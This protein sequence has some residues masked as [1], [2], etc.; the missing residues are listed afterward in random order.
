MFLREFRYTQDVLSSEGNFSLL[1]SVISGRTFDPDDEERL[2]IISLSL[3]STHPDEDMR[4]IEKTFSDLLKKLHTELL[5]RER[6]TALRT[7]VTDDA[8]AFHK[9]HQELV[10]KAVSLGISPSVLRS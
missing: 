9:M 5:I 4:H 3:E 2:K 7:S 1:F 10:Q 8:T 6:D